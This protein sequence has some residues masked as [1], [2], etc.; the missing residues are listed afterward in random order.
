[1]SL[2]FKC[3]WEM[4]FFESEDTEVF[5]ADRNKMVASNEKETDKFIPYCLTC[6]TQTCQLCVSTIVKM[7]VRKNI[8]WCGCCSSLIFVAKKAGKGTELQFLCTQDTLQGGGVEDHRPM[9]IWHL[10]SPQF[11]IQA[12]LYIYKTDNMMFL[13]LYTLI[14]VCIFSI[15]FSIHFVMCWQGEFV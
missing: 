12:I 1:M 13:T 9:F 5:K 10:H 2:M 14:P 6:F 3:S 15:L 11:Y 7:S 4:L 8:S